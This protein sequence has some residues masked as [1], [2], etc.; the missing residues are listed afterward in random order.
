M[1]LSRHTRIQHKHVRNRDL[2]KEILSRE[3]FFHVLD[4]RVVLDPDNVDRFD[5]RCR[6]D[7]RL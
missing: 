7:L 1:N 5:G 4:F 6:A 3:N 2:S